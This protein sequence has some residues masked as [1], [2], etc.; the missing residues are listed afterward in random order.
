MEKP[1][2]GV[3]LVG[4]L[5]GAVG[6]CTGLLGVPATG[7]A[8]DDFGVVLVAADA[9][10]HL[11]VGTNPLKPKPLLQLLLKASILGLYSKGVARQPAASCALTDFK[12]GRCDAEMADL[13]PG[14]FAFDSVA[15]DAAALAGGGC[16]RK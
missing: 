4:H 16:R 1:D 14:L 5:A 8:H 10:Q 3:K 9:G 15:V 6:I 13:L 7:S 2:A 12:S 11:V